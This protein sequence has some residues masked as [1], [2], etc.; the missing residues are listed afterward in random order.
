M[1]DINSPVLNPLQKD[2]RPPPRRARP[3]QQLDEPPGVHVGPLEQGLHALHPAVCVALYNKHLGV[4]IELGQ[5]RDKGN[6]GIIGDGDEAGGG[7]SEQLHQ[8]G[9]VVAVGKDVAP[10]LGIRWHCLVSLIHSFF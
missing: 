5:L 8:D 3:H 9:L 1:S 2:G 10:E 7:L 4:G 6:G